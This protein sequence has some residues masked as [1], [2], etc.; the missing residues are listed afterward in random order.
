VLGQ[1]DARYERMLQELQDAFP[2]QVRVRLAQDEALAHQLEA[3]ADIFL[4]PSQ[5][6][7]CGLSQLYSFK[8]GTVP[9]VRAT[10]GLRDTVVDATAEG[11]SA[12]KATGFIFIADTPAAFLQAVGRALELYRGDPERWLALMRAGMR[13]DWSW[14][15]SAAEYERLYL[16][17]RDEHRTEAG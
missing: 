14:G 6:E 2:A 5:F 8:Y 11:L 3:G 17:L 10:G 15:R 4:M 9:V 12:G 13:Q 1:G 7:P 16:R